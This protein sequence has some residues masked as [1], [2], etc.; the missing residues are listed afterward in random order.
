MLQ[1]SE[2]TDTSKYRKKLKF[3]TRGVRPPNDSGKHLDLTNFTRADIRG[4]Y[5]LVKIRSK[6]SSD[7]TF[8]AKLE[9]RSNRL[10]NCVPSIVRVSS[11]GI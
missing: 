4:P 1:F 9:Y 10:K 3:G 2:S 6:K 11:A 7:S 8:F 5:V